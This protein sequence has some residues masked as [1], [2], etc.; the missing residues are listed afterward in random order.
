MRLLSLPLPLVFVVFASA[1]ISACCLLL[2]LLL[3]LLKLQLRVLMTVALIAS[4]TQKCHLISHQFFYSYFIF[5]F[6]CTFLI[7]HFL[8][9]IYS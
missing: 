6:Y 9:N 3:V 4:L 5:D 8:L 7:F 1:A 2:L